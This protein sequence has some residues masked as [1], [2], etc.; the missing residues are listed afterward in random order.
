MRMSGA[1]WVTMVAGAVVMAA[2][3]E[4][5]VAPEP[6]RTASAAFSSCYGGLLTKASADRPG[7]I[8]LSWGY[9][10][11][12]ITI[13][14][15]YPGGA[16][17]LPFNMLQ[18]MNYGPGTNFV[19]CAGDVDATYAVSEQVV[20]EP[21]PVPAGVDA[22][23][24]TSLSPREQVALLEAAQRIMSLNPG[25]FKSSGEVIRTFFQPVLPATKQQAKIRAMDYYGGSVSGQLLAGGI[26]GC[27][28]YRKYQ[29][30]PYSPIANRDLFDFVSNLVAAF[31]E[32]EFASHPLTGL[33]FGR[34][35]IA[36]A[37]LARNDATSD[38]G[39]LVFQD[40]NRTVNVRDPYEDGGAPAEL[41]R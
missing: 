35:G 21:L 37:A 19:G 17:G 32:A 27:L 14:A 13:V 36:G 10:I 28:L 30:D 15:S 8:A 31:G 7:G 1:K 41:D 22:E 33:R 12:G 23:W 16:F 20:Q 11:S 4:S 6:E 39:F 9:P 34:N 29:Y 18:R 3:A 40:V 5:P 38:C 24:W 25:Q 2:C 26:Y